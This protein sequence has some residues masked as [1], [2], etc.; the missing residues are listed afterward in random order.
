[1]FSNETTVVYFKDNASLNLFGYHH[2]NLT[3]LK[4]NQKIVPNVFVADQAEQVH[5]VY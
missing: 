3:R 1:M 2:N 4:R 5:N